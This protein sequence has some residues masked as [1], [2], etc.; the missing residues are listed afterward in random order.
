MTPEDR[1][2]FYI[3]PKTFNWKEG[4]DLYIEGIQRFIWKEDLVYSNSQTSLIISKNHFRYFDNLRRVFVD[5]EI[6]TKEPARIRKDALMNEH[7]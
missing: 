2:C 3:D 1:E 6:L 4:V 7:V 5:S